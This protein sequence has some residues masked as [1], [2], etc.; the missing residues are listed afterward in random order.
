MVRVAADRKGT[1]SLQAIVSLVSR[2]IEEKLI[3][4]ALQGHIVELSFVSSKIIK[5]VFNFYYRILK[6]PI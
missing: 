5:E 3:R 1:H 2:D 4:D 6:E